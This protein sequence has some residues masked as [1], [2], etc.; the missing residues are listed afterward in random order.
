MK[1]KNI[2]AQDIMGVKALI[3]KGPKYKYKHHT[4]KPYEF[5]QFFKILDFASLAKELLYI[6]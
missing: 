5:T 6:S 3:S 2:D 4:K 1:E